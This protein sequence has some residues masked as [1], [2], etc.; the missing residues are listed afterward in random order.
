MYSKKVGYGKIDT[1]SEDTLN[2]ESPVTAEFPWERA[3]DAELW[4]L[5]CS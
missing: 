5:L 1:L 2:G 4:C 3:G